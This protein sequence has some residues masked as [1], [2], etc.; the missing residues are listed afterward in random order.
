MG[1]LAVAGTETKEAEADLRVLEFPQG[2]QQGAG[3]RHTG[4]GVRGNERR[5]PDRRPQQLK[6]GGQLRGARQQ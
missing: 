1:Q 5:V 4:R 2:L 3:G 6:E